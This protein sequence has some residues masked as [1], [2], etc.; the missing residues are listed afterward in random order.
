[1]GLEYEVKFLDVDVPA[2]KKILEK[3]GAKKVHDRI[4][5]K[6]TIFSRC[7]TTVK[8]YSRVRDEGKEV[9]MTSKMF[10][11]PKYPEEHEVT[12]KEDYETGVNFLKSLGLD[13]KAVQES[14]R[15]KWSHPLANEITFDDL[16]GLPTYMEVECSTE[17]NLNKLIETLGLDKS[18]M[19][20]GV[21]DATYE[22][23]YGIPRDTLNNKTPSLTFANIINEIK[24]TKNMD[25]LKSIHK[26]Y[27]LSRI[28]RLSRSKSSKSTKK[29]SKK[30]SK[31]TSKK[32]SKT[33][34]TSKK[35][36]KKGSLR[37]GSKK[38]GSKITVKK[39]SVRTVKKSSRKT[40]RKTS[41]KPVKKSS[42]KTKNSRKNSKKN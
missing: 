33:I 38:R 39:S 29:S 25:L 12:I 6:R 30:L 36:S 26:S 32:P 3:V 35:T 5:F 24:P 18:K 22:E 37:G 21:Y 14:Y 40:S 7:D 11:D 42:R 23:Y 15:E 10:K 1:M 9:T 41:R 34:K 13:V 28:G 4:M 20:Y 17:A 19:R 8:G 16:P 27:G 2:V 31:K